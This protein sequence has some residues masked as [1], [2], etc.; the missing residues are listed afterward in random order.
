MVEPSASGVLTRASRG[1]A[2]HRATAC[3][4]VLGAGGPCLDD[5]R[6]IS[7]DQ[8]DTVFVP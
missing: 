7:P 1:G 6:D 5:F 8:P 4:N 3:K 2:D